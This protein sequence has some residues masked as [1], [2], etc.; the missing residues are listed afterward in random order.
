MFTSNP[1]GFPS[2]TPATLS[3]PR[4]PATLS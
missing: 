3:A 1:N 2:L 4:T